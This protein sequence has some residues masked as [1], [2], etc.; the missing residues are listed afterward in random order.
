MSEDAG[1]FYDR[2]DL[3]GIEPTITGPEVEAYAAGVCDVLR[4]L[5]IEICS[6]GYDPMRIDF[7]VVEPDTLLNEKFEP[8]ANPNA[9]RAY[10]VARSY[11]FDLWDG[12][13]HHE[14]KSLEQVVFGI[15]AECARILSD[16]RD[17]DAKTAEWYTKQAGEYDALP[18]IPA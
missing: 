5:N 11:A 18:K 4:L 3:P 17:F 13:R 14:F 16:Q 2:L 15:R 12:G 8:E 6:K 10:N 7:G 9:G 1:T